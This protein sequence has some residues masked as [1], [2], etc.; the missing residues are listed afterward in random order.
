MQ[1]LSKATPQELNPNTPGILN[2][3]LDDFSDGASTCARSESAS[4]SGAAS[5][6]AK[7]RAGKHPDLESRTATIST[8]TER[9]MYPMSG[10]PLR[11][12][13]CDHQRPRRGTVEAAGSD[14]GAGSPGC[15][16]CQ[17]E[18]DSQ[19]RLSDAQPLHLEILVLLLSWRLR[20]QTSPRPVS[21]SVVFLI[22]NCCDSWMTYRQLPRV[23]RLHPPPAVPAALLL[24]HLAGAGLSSPRSTRKPASFATR[25]LVARIAGA[26]HARTC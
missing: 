10:I 11:R 21:A 22:S 14:C 19:G 4:A 15:P 2:R 9:Q 26:L 3:R 5:D 8:I 25:H 6:L 1:S 20:Y 7:F 23:P 16:C 18:V 12:H 13:G 17:P 24:G